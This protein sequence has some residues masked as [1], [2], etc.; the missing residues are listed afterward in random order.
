MDDRDGLVGVW[1]PADGRGESGVQIF[2]SGRACDGEEH[3][4]GA[5]GGQNSR[6]GCGDFWF[7][8]LTI[9]VIGASVTANTFIILPYSLTVRDRTA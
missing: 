1:I 3:V 7:S 6:T 5:F 2:G 9:A 8:R 4:G